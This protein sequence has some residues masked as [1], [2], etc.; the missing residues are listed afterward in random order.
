MDASQWLGIGEFARSGGVSIKA[1]RLY[2]DLGLLQPAAVKPQSRYRLYTRSQ[3][4]TL[5]RILLLKS[6]GFAL[7]GVRCRLA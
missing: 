5:H 1:L 3:L 2:A 6:A 7:A 4:P